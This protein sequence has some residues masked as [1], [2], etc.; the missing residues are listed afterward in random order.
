M[1][2][3]DGNVLMNCAQVNVLDGIPRALTCTHHHTPH[4]Y[5]EN[6]VT[7]LT[8]P[9]HIDVEQWLLLPCGL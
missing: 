3:R 1:V 4:A 2:G 6:A 7:Q 5:V 9:L 8:N